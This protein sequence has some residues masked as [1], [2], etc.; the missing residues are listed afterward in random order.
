M[1]EDGRTLSDYSIEKESTLHLVRPLVRRRKITLVEERSACLA[2]AQCDRR[3][4][5]RVRI[6]AQEAAL[7]SRSPRR[8]HGPHSVGFSHRTLVVVQQQ[9]QQLPTKRWE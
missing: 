1:G 9:Q 3:P 8:V 6:Y 4:I 2:V 5:L 7:W